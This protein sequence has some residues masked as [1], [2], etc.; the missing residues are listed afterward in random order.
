MTSKKGMESTLVYLILAVVFI[1]IM[2]AIIF[3]MREDGVNI[4]DSLPFF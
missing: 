1:F 2:M 3:M 4:I